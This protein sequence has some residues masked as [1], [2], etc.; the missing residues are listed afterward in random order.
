MKWH[1]IF[2]FFSLKYKYS[3]VNWFWNI[4]ILILCDIVDANE[5]QII[6]DN[7][8]EFKKYPEIKKKTD[9]RKLW[10]RKINLMNNSLE[11]VKTKKEYLYD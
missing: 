5:S 11:S 7:L 8:H 10:W 2:F 6:N 4:E 9:T 1:K 3:K